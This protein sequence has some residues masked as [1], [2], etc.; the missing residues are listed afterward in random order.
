[1]INPDTVKA[2][3]EGVTIFGLTAALK[4]EITIE[5]GRVMQHHF[6]DYPVI[7]HNEAPEVEVHLCRV[8]KLQAESANPA[9]RSPPVRWSM[10]SPP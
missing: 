4:G 5:N 2:Q 9:R 3:M 8:R 7:R 10:R 6:N 1:V